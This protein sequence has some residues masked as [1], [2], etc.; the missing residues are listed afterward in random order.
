MSKPGSRRSFLKN[1]GL[2]AAVLGLGAAVKAA[3]QPQIQGFA[4]EAT[5]KTA[6][7]W[8]PVSDRKIRMGIVG[9]G[10]CKFGAQWSA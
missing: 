2:G 3:E 4:E 5:E 8:E 1:T 9:Y 10:A 7:K 6:P